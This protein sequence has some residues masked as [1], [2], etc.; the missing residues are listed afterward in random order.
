MWAKAKGIKLSEAGLRELTKLVRGSKTPSKIVLRARII[1]G[2]AEGKSNNGMANELRTS[3]PTILLWRRRFKEGGV[4]ALLMHVYRAAPEKKFRKGKVEATVQ[5][6]AVIRNPR[7]SQ[8]MAGAQG[9]PSGIVGRSSRAR[10]LKSRK[11]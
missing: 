5:A 6:K 1:L 8:S 9:V 10:G 4:Q 2:A 3:R 11:Q 7:T